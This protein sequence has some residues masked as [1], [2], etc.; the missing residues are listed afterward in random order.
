MNEIQLSQY[1][2]DHQLQY[3]VD[4]LVVRTGETKNFI[5]QVVIDFSLENCIV[6]KYDM[7]IE[8]LTGHEKGTYTI[9]DLSSKYSIKYLTLW[10]YIRD[11]GFGYLLVRPRRRSVDNTFILLDLLRKYPVLRVSRIAKEQGLKPACRPGLYDL[12][13]LYNITPV[14]MGEVKIKE[15]L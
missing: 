3:S 4:Q 13:D 10:R 7:V 14:K 12:C 8:D 11:I 6:T 9:L 5:N 1:I 2:K 15:E